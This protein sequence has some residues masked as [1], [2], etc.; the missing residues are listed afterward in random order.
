MKEVSVEFSPIHCVCIEMDVTICS[1]LY[2]SGGSVVECLGRRTHNLRSRVHLPVA[3]LPGSL[4]LRQV[5]IFG[6]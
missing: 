4:F 6:R 1:L 5:T 2:C 3:T